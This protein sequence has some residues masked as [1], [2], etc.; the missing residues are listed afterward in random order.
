MKH[1]IRLK[2]TR[3]ALPIE[4]IKAFH[5]FLCPLSVALAIMCYGNKAHAQGAS[6]PFV[7]YEAESGVL[8]GGNWRID[9]V[10]S[11]HCMLVWGSGTNASLVNPRVNNSWGDGM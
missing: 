7:S 11:R 3:L 4:P 8:G 2:Q 6:L 10:W 5:R 1:I 9:N